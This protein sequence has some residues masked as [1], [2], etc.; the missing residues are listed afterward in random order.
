MAILQRVMRSGI[1]SKYNRVFLLV[2]KSVAKGAEA[3]G[4]EVHLVQV[5]ETLSDDVLAKMHAP[6]KD[7]T[8]PTITFGPSGEGTIGLEDALVNCDGLLLGYPTR[9]GNMPAQMKA[10]W[11][12][13]GRLWTSGGL[14]GKPVSVFFS[15]ATQGGG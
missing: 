11:D 4:A 12:A 9:F 15:S 8:I 2:A 6:P 10:I 7:K 13:T 1:L 14:V 5:P 3:A